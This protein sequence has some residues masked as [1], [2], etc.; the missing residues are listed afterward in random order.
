MVKQTAPASKQKSAPPVLKKDTIPH[1]LIHRVLRAGNDM[2][3]RCITRDKCRR[4][5]TSNEQYAPS[6]P[7]PANTA[8]R[9]SNI[10]AAFRHTVEACA[11]GM[12]FVRE[13]AR[14]PRE[15]DVRYVGILTHSEYHV[16]IAS[17]S[18]LLNSAIATNLTRSRWGTPVFKGGIF[19]SMTVALRGKSF[20][21]GEHAP[22]S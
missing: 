17:I 14:K 3:I 20:Q 1:L 13:N 11:F 12:R 18:S 9:P 7:I 2:S 16:R 8:A 22:E 19:P 10:H 15:A 6:K 5:P 4:I 21:T